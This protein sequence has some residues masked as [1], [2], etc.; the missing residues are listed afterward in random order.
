MGRSGG[1]SGMAT[2]SMGTGSSSNGSGWTPAYERTSDGKLRAVD[3]PDD[4]RYYASWCHWGPLIAAIS[5]M[6]TSGITFIIPPLVALAMWQIRNKD[7]EFI[8]DHGRE[9]LNFQISL[10]LLGL[11]LIPIT[12]LTCG[13]A[14][15]GYIGLPIL[16]IIGGI[17]GG[18]SANRGEVFRYPM[19]I[20]VIKDPTPPTA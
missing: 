8:D 9:A 7:S 14:A 6:L 3:L 12:I 16:A 5:V 15:I 20:R 4:Q 18:V 19:C 10:V 11:I 1:D 13:V 17:L 2:A